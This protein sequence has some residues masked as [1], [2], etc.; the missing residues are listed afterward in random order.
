MSVTGQI[1]NWSRYRITKDRP[2]VIPLHLSCLKL[3]QKASKDKIKLNLLHEALS[4]RCVKIYGK[5]PLALNYNYGQAKRFQ[6]AGNWRAEKFSESIVIDPTEVDG[7]I[8]NGMLDEATRDPSTEPSPEDEYWKSNLYGNHGW[9]TMF[10]PCETQLKKR[11]INWRTL[12]ILIQD[13]GNGK[14][15]HGSTKTQLQFRN[16]ARVWRVCSSILKDYKI[17]SDEDKLKPKYLSKRQMKKEM[18]RRRDEMRAMERQSEIN[19][20][21]SLSQL[22]PFESQD[23]VNLMES[24]VWLSPMEKERLISS[25]T[26]QSKISQFFIRPH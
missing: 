3:L 26:V 22:H 5:D 14:G 9:F 7:T 4:R 11:S 10:L 24:Q 2:P 17:S 13:L 18:L 6:A 20:M 16:R 15:R 25:S 1:T 23:G 12:H 21:E 8:V 19:L